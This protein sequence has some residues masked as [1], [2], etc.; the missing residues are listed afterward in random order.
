MQSSSLPVFAKLNL[1]AQQ[2]IVVSNA[3][4]EGSY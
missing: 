4:T 2:E 1:A 3:P